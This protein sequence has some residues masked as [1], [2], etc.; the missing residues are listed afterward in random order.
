MMP[1]R[2]RRDFWNLLAILK[3]RSNRPAVIPVPTDDGH[4]L[5]D[6]SFV[7]QFPGIPIHNIRVADRVPDDEVN[8]LRY[9]FYE[10]QVALYRLFPP[11]QPGLPSRDED[12][13][14]ALREAYTPAHRRLFPAPEVPQEYEGDVDLGLLAVAGPYAGYLERAPEGGYH[15]DL[16]DLARYEHH[17]GLRSLGV[18]VLFRLDQERSR[19]DAV[20]IDCELGQCEPGGPDWDLAKKLALCAVTN[21]VSLVRHFNW[22]HLAVGGPFA[23][24][25][26][27]CLGADHP[28]RRLLWPHVFGTQSSNQIATKGQMA[29]G[30]DFETVFSFTHAGMCALYEDSY[31][32][33]DVVVLDPA[34]DAERRGIRG[35]G[36]D[37]PTLRNHEALFDVMHAH[38]L[39]YLALYYSS[40]EEVR[41]DAAVVD[42]MASLDR[43]VPNGIRTLSG[44]DVTIGSTARLI[45]ALLYLATVQHEFLGTGLWNYQMWT[46]VQPVRVYEDGRRE[47]VDVYQRLVNANFTLNVRRAPLLQDFS[48][49]ALDA[50]GADAFR[51]FT[52]DLEVL[53]DRLD[54]E[55]FAHWKVLP[56]KLE[57][58]INA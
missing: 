7:S 27:N 1:W 32:D 23:I 40:D 34:R 5:G 51:A 31:A 46:H 35:A 39:R 11:M 33:Y 14:E 9:Y 21:H 43:L 16:R 48:Y 19:L 22:V 49:L 45:A 15:W 13:H 47:P 53:Q 30:G 12:P 37:T 55:P 57:A 17:R 36:F 56:R 2:L 18:R 25:T 8:R 28:V 4:R 41:A 20:R 24:A 6:V 26:R 54:A 3:Y 42:W 10:L 44:P 52:K 29:R 58:N 38:A 50:R